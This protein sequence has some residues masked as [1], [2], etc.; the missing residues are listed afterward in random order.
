[1]STLNKLYL[2]IANNR[3]ESLS[4]I[5]F[6]HSDIYFIR[7]GVRQRYGVELSLDDIENRLE[8]LSGRTYINRERPVKS[9]NSGT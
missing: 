2:A 1:M 8:E 9:D 7:E 3:P 4:E 5:H 6:Y